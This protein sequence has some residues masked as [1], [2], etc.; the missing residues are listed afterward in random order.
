MRW[1]IKFCA[2]QKFCPQ[3]GREIK[4][5]VNTLPFS[6]RQN[7]S[8][9]S[10]CKR[11]GKI[12]TIRRAAGSFIRNG[13]ATGFARA[14]ERRYGTQRLADVSLPGVRVAKGDCSGGR[15]LMAALCRDVDDNL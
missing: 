4:P 5:A 9:A 14:I 3:G 15:V 6:E 2:W 7:L 1:I 12:F 13:N 10:H 11:S 8:C